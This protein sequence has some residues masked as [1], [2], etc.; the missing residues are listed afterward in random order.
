MHNAFINVVTVVLVLGFMILIHEYGHYIAARLMGVRVDVFSIGFGPRIW[1]FRR[2]DTD[3]RLSILP[4][5]GYVKMAGDNP[6][7][8]RAGSDDEFLSK[9]RWQRVVIAVAGPA[10]NILFAL[11]VTLALFMIGA[12]EAAYMSKTAQ[13]AGVL[14][15]SPAAQAGIQP[16]DTI[17]KIDARKTPTWEDAIFETGVAPTG[18]R[19]LLSVERNGIQE[20]LQ[21]PPAPPQETRDEYQLLGYPR[22]PVIVG[23]VI[24]GKPASKAG[25]KTDD[26]ILSA[27]G[28]PML[29]PVQFATL[30][31]NSDGKP[32]AV[33]VQRAGA[34]A[35]APEELTLV[36]RFDDPGDGQ[37]RWQIGISFGADN[38][39][40]SHS[41]FDAA[42]RSVRF[43]YRMTRQILHV[44]A[45]L[46]QGKVSLKQLGGPVGIAPQLGEAVRHSFLDLISLTAVISL[47]LGILNLLPIPILDGGHVLLLAVE[48]LLRRDLSVA[49]KERF[50]QVGM[51]FLLGVI[52]LTTYYDILKLL[53]GR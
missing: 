27:D 40:A 34:P 14:P 18:A 15:G 4:L 33:T 12:P 52:V 35:G 44:L 2:G 49:V 7:E 20:F 32:V 45:G 6:I 31:R 46:F 30:V 42:D 39:Y 23:T 21:L 3:Y 19:I 41:F 11:V 1:G 13:V 47:N 8:E 29:S 53:P 38:V 17:V 43:N 10:M 51:V 22:S 9:P 37:K 25:L 50:V 48:G 28:Q 24:G 5:G 36:P 26:R 16:G